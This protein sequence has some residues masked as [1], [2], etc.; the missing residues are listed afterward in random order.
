MTTASHTEH[1]VYYLEM[2]SASQLIPKEESSPLEVRECRVKQFAFN[3]FLYDF[4]GKEWEWFDRNPWSDKQWRD[5]AEADDLR[6]WLAT[7]DGSPAGYFELQ[8]T[9]A[10]EVEIVYFGLAADFIGKGF[11][12]Y[13]LTRAIEAAWGLP[14]AKRVWVHTCTLDHPSALKNYQSRGFTIYHQGAEL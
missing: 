6:T 8:D 7:I 14:G 5:Y 2:T 1:N 3:R 11:G 10:G 12:G 4:V 9:P 13:L